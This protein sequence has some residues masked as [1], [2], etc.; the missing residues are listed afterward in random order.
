MYNRD[1]KRFLRRI[2]YSNSPPLEQFTTSPRWWRVF[3][4]FF[5]NLTNALLF[6]FF[7]VVAYLISLPMR[8]ARKRAR[9]RITRP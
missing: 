1:M 5:L 9:R 4:S 6:L 3:V 7:A 2:E 8:I